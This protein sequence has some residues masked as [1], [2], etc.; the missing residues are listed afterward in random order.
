MSPLRIGAAYCFHIPGRTSP[1]LNACRL[2]DNF[3]KTLQRIAQS[4]NY[5][6]KTLNLAIFRA[7][8]KALGEIQ[9]QNHLNS[10]I[11]SELMDLM[12][13]WIEFGFIK[14]SQ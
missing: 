14:N 4:Q 5:C 2:T 6:Q 9:E 1:T 3:E 8:M 11:R 12:V 7:S 13:K 10:A